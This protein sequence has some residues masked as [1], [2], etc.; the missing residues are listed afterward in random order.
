MNVYLK[1]IFSALLIIF[2]GSCTKSVVLELE[3]GEPK[4]VIEASLDWERGTTGNEQTFKLM[5]SS[6]YYNNTIIPAG[7]AAVTVTSSAGTVYNFLQ[8]GTS[9]KYSC[10][11][12]SPAMNESYT[13][14]VIYKG[15][16]YEAT[17]V[18]EDATEVVSVEQ[19]NDVSLDG[20]QIG[21]QYKLK[22]MPVNK[23]NFY[24]IRFTTEGIPFPGFAS[25]DDRFTKGQEIY[26]LYTDKELKQGS[27]V[28]A[29]VHGIDEG[30]Y[31]YIQKLA[32][33][34]NRAENP[35][36]TLPADVKGNIINKTNT[37]KAPFGYFRASVTTQHTYIVQ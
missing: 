35:F 2:L 33:N 29:V 11:N 28:K 17:E 22:A 5:L 20:K 37:D 25:F 26:A 14:K 27:K 16:T 8:D 1:N 10:T 21:L 32:I 19:N 6:P 30:T 12:F 34:G 36:A 13:L 18:F 7:G 3:Q 24:Y 4:L 9:E 23:D 31:F 15:N